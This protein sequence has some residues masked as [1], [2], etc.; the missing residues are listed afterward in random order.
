MSSQPVDATLCISKLELGWPHASGI[1]KSIDGNAHPAR[2]G[3]FSSLALDFR[4]VIFP[5]KQTAFLPK[6]AMLLEQSAIRQKLF[7]KIIVK[8]E[9]C[10]IGPKFKKFSK[11]YTLW[12]FRFLCLT[13][14]SQRRRR[15]RRIWVE[16]VSYT[17]ETLSTQ[18]RSSTC[19]SSLANSLI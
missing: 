12:V 5:E 10:S 17:T 7:L 2:L 19:V 18:A 14:L 6:R 4:G 16:E 1:P 15:R 11:Y 9:A 13:Q 3:I 8:P